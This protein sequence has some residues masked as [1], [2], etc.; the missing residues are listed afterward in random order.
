MVLAP[1][2]ARA[3]WVQRPQFDFST[4]LKPCESLLKSPSAAEVPRVVVGLG[5]YGS[6]YKSSRHNVGFQLIDELVTQNRA[7]LIGVFDSKGTHFF[8]SSKE[9]D[10]YLNFAEASVAL[11]D[12]L[13][14]TSHYGGEVYKDE[15]RNLIF[16]KPFDDINESGVFVGSLLAS[17]G[18]SP[19]GLIVIYDEIRSSVNQL[20]VNRGKS[21]N[22]QSDRHNGLRSINAELTSPSYLRVSVGV[23][24]PRD[25]GLDVSLQ[26]WV[27]G[28][29]P[30]DQ[31]KI[32]S[33]DLVN[34]LDQFLDL[35]I[36]GR[37]EKATEALKE[38]L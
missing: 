24:N 32:L 9:R 25:E 12:R 35:M 33:T 5:N 23:S 1:L 4:L 36:L 10:E 20:K 15:R 19:E 34:K 31:K 6:Q 17:L 2:V 38:S 14:V 21:I 29:L 11:A 7:R 13:F 18:L 27:L 26:D 8:S 30:E 3:N 22:F 16:V 28:D 37:V